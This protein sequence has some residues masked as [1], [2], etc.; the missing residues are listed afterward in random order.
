MKQRGTLSC[1][2]EQGMQT[3]GAWWTWNFKFKEIRMDPKNE[4]VV[5][6]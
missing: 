1:G 3:H 6:A 5:A 4:M 2:L